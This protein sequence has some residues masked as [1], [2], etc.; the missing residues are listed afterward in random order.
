MKRRVYEHHICV[1]DHRSGGGSFIFGFSNNYNLTV[2]TILVHAMT[3]GSPLFVPINEHRCIA[4]A[5]RDLCPKYGYYTGENVSFTTR[6]QKLTPWKSRTRNL[7][8]VLY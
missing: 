1:I 5:I 2:A 4:S 6:L 3:I 7:L 8:R